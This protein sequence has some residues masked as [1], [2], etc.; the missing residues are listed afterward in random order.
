MPSRSGPLDVAAISQP[1]SSGSSKR[2]DGLFSKVYF[3]YFDEDG[4]A[5]KP[6]LLP[7]KDPAFYDSC[8]ETFNVPELVKGPVPVTSRQLSR[9]VVDAAQ[10]VEAEPDVAAT[11]GATPK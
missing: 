7:Q 8:I 2:R 6:F 11:S 3:S 4:K 5:H 1:H 10:A 9:A